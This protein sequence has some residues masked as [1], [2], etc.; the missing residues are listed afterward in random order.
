M[1]MGFPRLQ[2]VRQH[3][4]DHRLEDI[5][6]ASARTERFGFRT[7]LKPGA[8]VAI[9]VGSRGIANVYKSMMGVL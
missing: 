2:T 6:D 4:P 1:T 3:F 5:P 7:K 9:G 8:R